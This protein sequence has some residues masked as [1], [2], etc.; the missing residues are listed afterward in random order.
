MMLERLRRY[1]LRGIEQCRLTQNRS[2]MVSFRGNRLRVHAAFLDAP[3]EVLRA[4]VTFVNGR[5]E[6][7]RAAKRRILAHDVP[8]DRSAG[9]RRRER[10]HADDAGMNR[11]LLD[12]HRLFNAQHFGGALL[13]I[14]V[15]VSRRMKTRLGH[16]TP[17]SP[18]GG[19]AEIAI[20]R[21]HIRRHGWREALDTLLHEMVHQW[22]AESG[23][24]LGHGPD[25]RAKARAV[26]G[27]PAAVRR[28]RDVSCAAR[29][30]G[31]RE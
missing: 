5:G 30:V 29:A 12:A 28:S 19:P 17:A 22:Q 8:R 23:R 2:T 26:G 4:I 10:P 15:R 31:G 3:P 18:D 13:P 9:P 20:S 24:P 27:P 7:R 11:R 1:G 16:F 25:F 6:P 21:R 14:V